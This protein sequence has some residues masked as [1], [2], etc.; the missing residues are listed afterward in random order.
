MP[1]GF[2]TKTC[3]PALMART[4]IAWRLEFGV[5][6]MTAFTSESCSRV[7]IDV[8]Q[9]PS[10]ATLKRDVAVPASA[11]QNQIAEEPEG[12]D[13]QRLRPI[14]PQPMIANFISI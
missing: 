1:P 4:A 10:L 2:S 12:G 6:T 13:C 3:L 5:A 8:L 11:S 14:K 7:S 9:H